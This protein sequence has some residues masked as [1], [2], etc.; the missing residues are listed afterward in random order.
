MSDFSVLNL[1]VKHFL[2]DKSPLALLFIKSRWLIYQREQCGIF[3]EDL[4]QDLIKSIRSELS[5]TT[6]VH[7]TVIDGLLS[8]YSDQAE[9]KLPQILSILNRFF[10]R[11]SSSAQS[12]SFGMTLFAT[13]VVL[14]RNYLSTELISPDIEVIR[15]VRET[16]PERPSNKEFSLFLKRTNMFFY[17]AYVKPDMDDATDTAMLNTVI[18]IIR[19]L[20]WQMEIFSENAVAA[21]SKHANRDSQDILEAITK[22]N[23]S[24]GSNRIF[25]E[26]KIK[27]ARNAEGR[28]E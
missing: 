13:L 24:F 11:R 8:N 26:K 20:S 12:V 2:Y 17:S 22:F 16:V 23:E 27:K 19:F 1:S 28:D 10:Y 4:F 21:A 7:R 25:V 3:V 15:T 9:N 5:D 6:E 18:K 14:F